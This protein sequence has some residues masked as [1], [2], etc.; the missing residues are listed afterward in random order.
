M[1]A[2]AVRLFDSSPSPSRSKRAT[3]A[4]STEGPAKVAKVRP[5][6]FVYARR[7]VFPPCLVCRYAQALSWLGLSS[8]IFDEALPAQP[9]E[10]VV[11]ADADEGKPRTGV[12]DV[13]VGDVRAIHHAIAVERGRHVEISNLS[14]LGNAPDV[15][16]RAVVA[17][18]HLVWV[19]DHFIDEVAEVEHESKPLICRSAAV[20]PDHSAKRVLRPFIDA[21]ARDERKAY[22]P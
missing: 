8:R 15:V 6:R 18:R 16:D 5:G 7:D 17:T 3:G 10:L 20:F 4:F 1:L 12:L 19:F 2:R 21:L 22:R 11:V 9:R 14:P 13:R